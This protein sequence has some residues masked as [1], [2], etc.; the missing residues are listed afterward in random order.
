[1]EFGKS[2]EDLARKHRT[3]TPHRSQTNGIAEKAIRRVKEGTSTVLLPSGLDERRWSGSMECCCYLRDVQDL[4]A[5]GKTP[6]ERRFEEPFK[7]PLIPFGAT[8]VE[9]HPISARDQSRTHQ[10]GKKF[11]LLG[12]FFSYELADC[13]LTLERRYSDCNFGRFGKVGRIRSS[14]SKNQRERS[15][16]ITKR[17]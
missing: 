9:Y 10:F 14:S 15:I 7:G 3:S 16:D 12:I 4:M 13:G 2:C 6:Y 17:R 1:M 8:L 5:D 11:V